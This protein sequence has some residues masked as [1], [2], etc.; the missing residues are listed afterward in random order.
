MHRRNESWR[1][2]MNKGSFISMSEIK[3]PLWHLLPP[4]QADTA[5][6]MEVQMTSY[7]VG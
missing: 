4:N 5:I 6:T 7:C 2:M 3:H 1:I